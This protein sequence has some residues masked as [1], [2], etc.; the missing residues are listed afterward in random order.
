MRML[1][2]IGAAIALAMPSPGLAQVDA[3]LS[4]GHVADVTTWKTVSLGSFASPRA[5]FN[6]LDTAGIHIG[7]TAEE[8]LHRSGFTVGKVKTRVQLVILS[9]ADLGS[10]EPVSLAAFY[11]R[12]RKLGYELCPP[13][14]VAQ[15]RLQ[16]RDQPVGEFLNVA[17]EPIATFEGQL[18]GLSVANGGAGLM[19]VGEPLSLDSIRDRSARFVFVRPQQIARPAP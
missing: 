14:A 5:L 10:G 11:A 4:A 16:Y 8:V 1:F 2:V 19:I 18:T 17:M 3:A 13:E 12:A 7:D 15:L 6:A 9:A